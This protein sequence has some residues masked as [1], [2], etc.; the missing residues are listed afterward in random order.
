MKYVPRSNLCSWNTDLLIEI[1]IPTIITYEEDL[2]KRVTK[3]G[4]L[5]RSTIGV[6]IFT[7]AN[8]IDAH[9]PRKHRDIVFMLNAE[10]FFAED[11]ASQATP[12][13]SLPFGSPS[14]LAALKVDTFIKSIFRSLNSL[15]VTSSNSAVKMTITNPM[16]SLDPMLISPWH[17][18]RFRVSTPMDYTYNNLMEITNI[19]RTDSPK[20]ESVLDIT[21]LKYPQD[22]NYQLNI[23][24]LPRIPD[25]RRDWNTLCLSN[26]NTIESLLNSVCSQKTKA[27]IYFAA[28]LGVL[29][30]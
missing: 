24:I 17:F 20:F 13:P 7:Y 18:S 16:S 11:I 30:R 22:N 23:G 15:G 9:L 10:E 27:D 28:T 29:V 1:A 5:L 4:G 6:D 21:A 19:W 12:S 26:A 2:L 14:A 3:A 8:D 25:G